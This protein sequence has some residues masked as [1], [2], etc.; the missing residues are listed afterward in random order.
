MH[1]QFPLQALVRGRYCESQ[2]A[3][4][5]HARSIVKEDDEFLLEPMEDGLAIFAA[6]E[7]ALARPA[8]LLGEVFGG[9]IEVGAPSVRLIVGEPMQEPV[10]AIRV[11]AK[12]HHTSAV[13]GALWQ[14]DVKLL[15]ECVRGREFIVRGCAP[16]QD[17]MGLPGDL[18]SA[19]DGTA[20]HWIR[21]A[22]Y[23]PVASA[24]E[25]PA[26]IP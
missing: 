7:D 9:Q 17:V 6:N 15:E 2:H 26:A 12:R 3:F 18:A 11:R 4:A 8:R 23:A 1:Y 10:M 14:R 19:T 22:H 20:A 25:D 5:T 24:A 16:L 13:L 21:L